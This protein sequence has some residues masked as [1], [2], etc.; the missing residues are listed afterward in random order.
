MKMPIILGEY[1]EWKEK[2][3]KDKKTYPG[4]GGTWVLDDDCQIYTHQLKFSSMMI[5][6]IMGKLLITQ[7][8]AIRY[9]FENE[10]TEP[11][12]PHVWWKDEIIKDKYGVTFT[13]KWLDK[14]RVEFVPDMSDEPIGYGEDD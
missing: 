1:L 11:I 10:V 14:N 13:R 6:H 9:L 2:K 7:E 12:F 3:N 8:V 4:K 5:S